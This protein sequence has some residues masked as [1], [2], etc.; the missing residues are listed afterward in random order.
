VLHLPR[1]SAAAAAN[2]LRQHRQCSHCRRLRPIQAACEDALLPACP[3]EAPVAGQP[4]GEQ[5]NGMSSTS[6]MLEVTVCARYAGWRSRRSRTM[7]CNQ[8][9]N[10][11]DDWHRSS[12]THACCWMPAHHCPSMI[13]RPVSDLALCSCSQHSLTCTHVQVAFASSSTH[14]HC[15][16]MTGTRWMT[17]ASSIVSDEHYCREARPSVIR[18]L[19]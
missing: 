1:C 12:A 9:F 18:L 4:C 13:S 16:L 10:T 15:H 17:T 7:R 6:L 8:A 3:H 11:T 14:H 5:R 2:A 19:T